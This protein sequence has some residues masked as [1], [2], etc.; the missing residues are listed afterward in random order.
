MKR[1]KT[2]TNISKICLILFLIFTASYFRTPML[3]NSQT[4]TTD[5]TKNV[6]EMIQRKNTYA[7]YISNYSDL[8]RPSAEVNIP[9]EKFVKTDMDVEI[10]D[11]FE[12]Y[13]GKSIR[14]DEQGY[15]EWEVYVE[16]EGLYNIY[17]EYFPIEGRSTDIE[18]E[19]WINGE[20][21]FIDAKNL[22][23]SR[24]WANAEPIKRDNRDNDLRPRQ[25]ESPQWQGAW[26]SDYMGYYT[27]PYLFYFKS[28][29]N[30]LKLVSVKEPM[31]IRA[32]KLCQYSDILTYDEYLNSYQDKG[33]KIVSAEPIYIQGEDAAYKSDP[34][35]YP[36]NDRTSPSTV[37]YHKSKI[38][39]NTIGGYNWR[40]PGQWIAWNVEVGEAGFYQIVIKGRQNITRGLYSNRKLLINGEVP[41]KE[42][43][44]IPFKYSNTWQNFI[45]GDGEQPYLFYLK[46]G[47][48]EIRMEV[49]LGDLAEILRVAEDSVFI[50]N[51][52]YR[53]ILMITGRNP[54]QYRDYKLDKKLPEVIATFEKESKVLEDLSERLISYTGQ[55]GAHNGILD[56]LSYQLADMAKRPHTIQRRLQQF[57]DNVGALSTWILNTRE[58]P[59]E[60]DYIIVCHPST[61]IP[62]AEAS[63]IRRM[64][65][66]IS[67][68]F[69]IVY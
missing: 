13:Y 16:K 58:Q 44:N 37:P 54:D 1:E 26:F 62:K 6:G 20:S 63:L 36:I 24:V 15:I 45:L 2:I 38:R 68:F 65:H 8:D 34:T 40:L 33:V 67:A 48:N 7:D 19:L 57:K 60:I 50:L 52:A 23:F 25:V 12:G 43:E 10:Y 61:Q 64:T 42:A 18:R 39:L 32:I 59:L 31:V 47:I 49:V 35:L 69:C 14:T 55:R 21:P 30:T 66:E 22:T 51:S 9:V 27:E 41:F 11:N 46:E 5:T 28:G 56:R 17:I 4:S 29:K 3:A 53:K